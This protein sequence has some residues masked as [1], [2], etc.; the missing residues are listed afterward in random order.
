MG[1]LSTVGL[2]RDDPEIRVIWDVDCYFKWYPQTL[3]YV[4]FQLPRSRSRNVLKTNV[5]HYL[6]VS[7]GKVFRWLGSD[8]CISRISW[9]SS[10][11][12]IYQN[13]CRGRHPGWEHLSVYSQCSRL[14]C[15]IESD[16]RRRN[17]ANNQSNTFFVLTLGHR[18]DLMANTQQLR[19]WD[20][21]LL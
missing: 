7:F 19:S 1:S 20:R 6:C 18:Q 5:V 12:C 11:E 8:R 9:A 17:I 21:L 16:R 13:K 10:L 14:P 3:S 2:S 4:L 15:C